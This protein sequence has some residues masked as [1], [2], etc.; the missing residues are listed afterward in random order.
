MPAQK[1]LQVRRW[2]TTCKDGYWSWS[3]KWSR[4]KWQTWKI[5]SIKSEIGKWKFRAKVEF[6]TTKSLTRQEKCSDLNL[7]RGAY[8]LR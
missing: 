1:Y 7:A 6:I 2:E 3:L 8:S 4:E 5:V